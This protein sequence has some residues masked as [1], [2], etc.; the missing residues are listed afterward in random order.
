MLPDSSWY[1]PTISNPSNSSIVYQLAPWNDRRQISR[2][3][4]KRVLD[5]AIS[6]RHI[7]LKSENAGLP[8]PSRFLATL[9]RGLLALVYT[10]VVLTY[11]AT[12]RMHS[13]L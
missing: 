1:D 11:S 2:S 7:N 12:P 10:L 8:V 6:L 9:H 5:I 13:C 3:L 4:L